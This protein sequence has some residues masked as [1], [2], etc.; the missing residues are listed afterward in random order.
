MYVEWFNLGMKWGSEFMFWTSTYLSTVSWTERCL[1]SER[2]WHLCQSQLTINIRRYFWTF[3]KIY[4]LLINFWRMNGAGLALERERE[5]NTLH[6]LS[7]TPVWHLSFRCCS[8]RYLSLSTE[9]SPF[10]FSSLPLFLQPSFLLP[11][12]SGS[13]TA[14]HLFIYYTR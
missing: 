4:N 7:L 2:S 5:N 8:E 3:N 10:S 9:G 1:T 14:F 12:L 13:W 11:L 6:S